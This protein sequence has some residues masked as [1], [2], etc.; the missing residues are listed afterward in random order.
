MPLLCCST[1]KFPRDIGPWLRH[2]NVHHSSEVELSDNGDEEA[3][4]CAQQR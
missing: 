2:L 4:P 3:F 1:K